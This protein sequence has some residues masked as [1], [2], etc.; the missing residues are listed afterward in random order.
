M[1][2][3]RD[4]LAWDEDR[5][6]ASLSVPDSPE[7]SQTGKYAAFSDSTPRQ[8]LVIAL[9]VMVLHASLPLRFVVI[10]WLV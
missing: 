8:I 2:A 3:D 5:V 7:V 9:A 4:S 6:F 1:E 10:R